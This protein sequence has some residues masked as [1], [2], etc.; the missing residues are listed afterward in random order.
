MDGD[1]ETIGGETVGNDSADTF[2]GPGDEGGTRIN[3]RCRVRHGGEHGEKRAMKQGRA[4][5]VSDAATMAMTSSCGCENRSL[6][7]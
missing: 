7:G 1:G 5:T 6:A 2:G 3:G 4:R